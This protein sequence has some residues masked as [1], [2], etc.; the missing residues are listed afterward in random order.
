MHARR[1]TDSKMVC[2]RLRILDNIAF[3]LLLYITEEH[4][5]IF[6]CHQAIDDT[7][8]SFTRRSVLQLQQ[9]E[10]SE[11]KGTLLAYYNHFVIS[12]PSRSRK[13]THHIIP[14]FKRSSAWIGFPL[15]SNAGTISK[16]CSIDAMVKKSEFKLKKRPGHI[17]MYYHSARRTMSSFLQFTFDQTQMPQGQGRGH[18]DSVTRHH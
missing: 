8:E 2:S 7:L 9:S 6:S 3:V 18:P 12:H 1:I 14:G 10:L 15:V 16:V 13:L 11:N 5:W 17:L 4:Y